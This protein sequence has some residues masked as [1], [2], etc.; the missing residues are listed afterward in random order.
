LW[1][2]N[3][4]EG[5]LVIKKNKNLEEINKARVITYDYEFST[6]RYPS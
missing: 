4:K 5:E 6:G 2:K 3:L 1:V